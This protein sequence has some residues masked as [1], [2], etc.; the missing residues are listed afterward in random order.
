M[1]TTAGIERLGI[2]E[3]RGSIAFIEAV[4][5]V[6]Y[7]D[8]VEIVSGHRSIA[9]RVLAVT[10]TSAAV[11]IFGSTDGLR[12]A[13]SRVRFRGQPL[14]FGVGPELLGRV[15]DGVG[16]PADGL[17][18]PPPLELRPISGSAL[19]PVRREYPKDFLETGVSVIDAL[20]SIVLGQK[21]PI[22]TESG[23]RH[24]DLAMQIVRQARAPGV[25]KF[26][27]VFVA[28]GLPRETTSR[29]LDAFLAAGARARLVVFLNHADDPSA[30]RL[31][32]PRC[33]LTAAEY[34]AFDLGYHV[35]VVLTD[36]TNYGEALREISAA[37]GEVPSRKGYPGYLYS[38]LASLFERAGR[39]IGRPGSLTQIPIVT[40]PSGDMSHPIPDLTGYVTE[41]QI[42][43]D[44]ELARRGIYPPVSI[45]PSL[46]R[47]MGDGIGAGRTRED[48]SDVAKQLYAAVARVERARALAGIIGIDELTEIERTYL[49]FGERFEREFL[50]QSPQEHRSIDETLSIAWNVLKTL[51]HTELTR[52]RTEFLEKYGK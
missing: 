52:I 4:P 10:D 19:N 34:L 23:L 33:A 25:E 44:R 11:E 38:D 15:F 32:T 46:S 12:L 21:L 41:G 3:L 9:G 5:G 45:L 31:I 13:D 42:V 47:L 18:P 7:H 43:L 39:V 30:E 8:E 22:F 51:P 29:Y 27:I 2:R 17:P 16:R 1:L 6:G 14:R 24:D 40:L 26:A 48:H 49:K 37:R 20:Y 50:T 36:I 35:L 28:L